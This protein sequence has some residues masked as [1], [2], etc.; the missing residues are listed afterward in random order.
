MTLTPTYIDTLR[1]RI[2]VRLG[3]IYPRGPRLLAEPVHYAL[4][5]KGKRL[6]PILTQLACRACGGKESDALHAAVAVEILHN[7]TLVHDDIMDQDHTRHG[8]AT[9]HTKWDDS[10]G[11]LAGDALFIL[12]LAELRLSSGNV[13]A[14]ISA[15]AKGALAV[16]EGQ[17]LDKEFEARSRVTLDEY[18]QMIDLKTGYMLGLAAELGAICASA[19]REQIGGVRRFGSLLGRAFQVQDDALEVFSDTGIVG[20]SLGSDLLAEKKTYLMIAALERAPDQVRQAVDTATKDLETGLAALRETL[21]T[22][23]VK[24]EAEAIVRNT[25]NQAV[26]ELLPL[27][28]NADPLREFAHLVLNR[29][30]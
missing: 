17:A 5:G 20:K 14:H 1:Q 12:A 3:E 21:L 15:F 16:C 30:K 10:V 11:I 7:F 18:L 23:G 25:I 8:Q 4:A 13:E 19:A 9:V 27:G 28:R 2:N 29:K 6:R 24:E 22:T 26:T